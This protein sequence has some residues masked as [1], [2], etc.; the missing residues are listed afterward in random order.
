MTDIPPY[1]TPSQIGRAC[2]MTSRKAKS[3]L[4]RAGIL[5]RIGERWLV[6]ESQLRERLPEVYDRVYSHIVLRAGTDPNRP[7]RTRIGS[8]AVGS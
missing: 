8:E 6:G 5:E 4:R 7:E 2:R 1:L 3:L